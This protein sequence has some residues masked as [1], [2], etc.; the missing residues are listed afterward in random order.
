MK[1]RKRMARLLDFDFLSVWEVGHRWE[2]VDPDESDPKKL[3][4]EV[5]ERVRQVL[6]GISYGMLVPYDVQREEIPT[7]ELWFTG[8]RS[9]KFAK[10]LDRHLYQLIYDRTLLTSVFVSQD[11][12]EK[13]C[14]RMNQPL[15]AFWFPDQV[16]RWGAVEK[17]DVPAKHEPKTAS[18]LAKKAAQKRHEP[19]NRLKQDFFDFW[20]QGKGSFRSR[21]D[22]ARRFYKSLPPEK[23]K[24][25]VE[26]NA[27]RTL[28]Q[29][30]AKV[31]V[32]KAKE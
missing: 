7:E 28:T 17:D 26:S 15:P 30:L 29:A 6:Q 14:W 16:N 9:T 24:L 8:I 23:R 18:A 21:A 3:P 32:P 11:E 12:V 19:R 4:K 20:M 25:L 13:W 5:R 31:L 2:D 22:A 27:I 10:E 1:G